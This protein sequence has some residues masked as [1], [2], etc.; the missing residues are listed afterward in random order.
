MHVQV[1]KKRCSTTHRLLDV[2]Q[3]SRGKGERES[4]TCSRRNPSSLYTHVACKAGSALKLG[5]ADLAVGMRSFR[6]SLFLPSRS[7][8]PTHCALCVLGSP[9]LAPSIASATLPPS[10][11]RY[12]RTALFAQFLFDPIFN[13]AAQ[14]SEGESPR[15]PGGSGSLLLN[16]ANK[17]NRDS[18][19]RGAP[20]NQGGSF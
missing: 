20:C 8:S 12:V 19:S 15:R 5:H 18:R 3:G 2:R 14:K 13:A 16:C 7:Y 1:C 17:R 9:P 4:Q 11:P 6:R 10:L